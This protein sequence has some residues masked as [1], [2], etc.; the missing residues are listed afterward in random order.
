MIVKQP[1]GK[2][3]Y[4]IRDTIRINLTEDEY[5]QIRLKEEEIL[6]RKELENCHTDPV[7]MIK[8]WEV[9]DEDL[10]SMGYDK[11]Y[12]EM[13]KY[14]PKRVINSSYSSR[15]CMSFAH[16]PVCNTVVVDGMGTTT[17][18]CPECNQRLEWK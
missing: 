17:H 11:T 7:E 6:I 13:T 1:N 12:A 15:D 14:I 9:S 2:Y 4:L 3:C 8:R 10:R 5:I 18:V 16:C